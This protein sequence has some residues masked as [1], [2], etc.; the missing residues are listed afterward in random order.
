MRVQG[1]AAKLLVRRDHFAAVAR[2]HFH[3]VQVDIAED[4]V[5]RA[6]NEHGHAVFLPADSRRYRCDQ[7]SRELGLDVGRDGFQL[8]Q[9]LGQELQHA[10]AAD[11]CLQA[12]P[13]V[14][15]DET[16]CQPQ[17]AQ[18]HEQPADGDSADEVALR[19][20]EHAARFGFRAGV[21]EKLRVIHP[22]RASG[23]AGEA[24]EAEVH[25]VR[26]GPRHIQAAI[27]DRAHE[28]DAAPRAMS[29]DLRRV[30]GRARRQAKAAVHALLQDRVVEA[31]EVGRGARHQ[32]SSP[33]SARRSGPARAA[34]RASR[35]SGR[36]RR[37][38]AETT[39]S[40][41]RRRARPLWCR[42]AGLPRGISP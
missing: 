32:T 1:P 21:L 3:S 4:Q 28:R 33:G 5:L 39:S 15:P 35:A 41:R 38:W 27:G 14:E 19:R 36:R 20:S 30:V 9:S 8:A 24:A 16:A 26:E 34:A 37:T 22:C 13:L 31:L 7:L 11:E 10:G 29:L 6:A 17:M 12:K 25:F 2:E 18:V 40:T 42:P 23:H